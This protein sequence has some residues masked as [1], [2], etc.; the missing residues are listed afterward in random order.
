MLE[1]K[2]QSY[3]AKT[4]N[5]RLDW[6]KEEKSDHGKYFER[7]KDSRQDQKPKGREHK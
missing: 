3:G 7:W 6:I 1:G 2:N 4:R 5:Q